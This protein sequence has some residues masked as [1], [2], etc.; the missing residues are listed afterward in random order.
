MEEN[1]VVSRIL[2]LCNVRGWSIY[3]LAKESNIAYSTLCTMIHKKNTP[4]LFTLKRLCAGFGITIGEFLDPNSQKA[5]LSSEDLRCLSVF[6]ALTPENRALS[7][8]YMELLLRD[9]NR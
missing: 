1:E 2:A 4:S 8:Q 5:G 7:L 9:Q 6:S 3:R